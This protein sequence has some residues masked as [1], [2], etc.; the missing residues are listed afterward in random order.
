MGDVIDRDTAT[1]EE[2][3]SLRFE[4][5]GVTA[6]PGE[7]FSPDLLNVGYFEFSAIVD[8]AAGAF[9]RLNVGIV[10]THEGRRV[11]VDRA[12]EYKYQIA[13]SLVAE[14]LTP[15]D[16]ENAA[17]AQIDQ[18]TLAPAFRVQ[19]AGPGGTRYI[20]AGD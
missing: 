19:E 12:S 1:T 20:G 14:D 9:E 3:K 7:V 8:R 18:A 17:Y 4:S 11:L 16:L 6:P 5:W 10:V 2:I 13:R 15:F